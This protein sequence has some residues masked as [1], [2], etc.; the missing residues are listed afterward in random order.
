MHCWEPCH[1]LAA[2]A[3]SISAAAVAAAVV[4][5]AVVVGHVAG[6]LADGLGLVL[7]D[8]QLVEGC[9][10]LYTLSAENKNL[11]SC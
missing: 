9:W 2:V 1:S 10:L 11:L 7:H 5:V 6:R 8:E 3:A 4:F